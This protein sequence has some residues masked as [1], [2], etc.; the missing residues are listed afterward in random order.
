MYRVYYHWGRQHF[1]HFR[2]AKIKDVPIPLQASL[3][4][5]FDGE[6]SMHNAM[7]MRIGQCS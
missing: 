1:E 2:N 4:S 7:S 6:V 3:V 5:I